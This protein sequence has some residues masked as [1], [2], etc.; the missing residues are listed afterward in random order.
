MS[1]ESLAPQGDAPQADTPTQETVAETKTSSASSTSEAPQAGKKNKPWYKRFSLTT[2]IFIALVL[3]VLV[4]IPLQGAP[5]IAD[6]YIKPFGTVFLNLIK[7][8]VVPL[9]L[10]STM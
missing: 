3:G 10:F 8:I 9:V 4:G 1:D 2:W 7:M 5:E 6:T